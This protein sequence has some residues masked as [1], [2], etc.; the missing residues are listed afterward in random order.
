MRLKNCPEGGRTE[1]KFFFQQ[2]KS[3]HLLLKCNKETFICSASLLKYNKEESN[4]NV[5]LEKISF[6]L[7]FISQV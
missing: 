1:N 7:L 2:C 5:K 3:Y 4:C 6:E